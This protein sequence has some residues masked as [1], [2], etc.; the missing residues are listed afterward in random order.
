MGKSV[1]LNLQEDT[2]SEVCNVKKTFTSADI[3]IIIFAFVLWIIS[4]FLSFNLLNGGNEKAVIYVNGKVYASYVLKDINDKE[5]IEIEN[6]GKNIVEITKK[7]VRVTYS[8][9]KDKTEIREDY[10]NKSWQTL[11]CLPHK[12]VIKIEGGG[13]DIDEITY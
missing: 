7:G 5:I 10:I 2:I 1:I 3:K 9:C 12:L 11:V 4:I 13:D 6:H 8:D